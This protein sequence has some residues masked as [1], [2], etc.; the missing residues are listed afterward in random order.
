MRG[1]FS[2]ASQEYKDGLVRL[3]DTISEKGIWDSVEVEDVSW[4]IDQLE[5]LLD[6][7]SLP[8][9]LILHLD[10]FPPRGGRGKWYEE[11]EDGL[12]KLEPIIPNGTEVITDELMS[13]ALGRIENHVIIPLF[14]GYEPE[15]GG[16]SNKSLYTV[17]EE[18]ATKV[19]QG[20][21]ILSKNDIKDVLK[22]FDLYDEEA[23]EELN[24][25]DYLEAKAEYTWQMSPPLYFK[26]FPSK[27]IIDYLE[28]SYAQDLEF[29]REE[30][31]IQNQADFNKW[32]NYAYGLAI[33]TFQM[34]VNGEQ[35][36]C[37][38]SDANPFSWTDGVL[39]RSV[40]PSR[41]YEIVKDIVLKH[42]FSYPS[43]V[44]ETFPREE[45]VEETPSLV[46][47]LKGRFFGR[48]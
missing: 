39:L 4:V 44:M 34:H 16:L 1:E 47:R 48:R 21:G 42:D 14:I 40:D 37:L 24:P 22:R 3:G 2:K 26:E 23:K 6:P 45:K 41:L 7:L 9:Y 18:F 43:Y 13:M 27:T 25:K 15:V 33:L 31:G 12:P 28:E 19:V 35:H 32:V 46:G 10:S 30:L 11:D 8:I 17:G 5:S 36:K 38:F 20:W 29:N